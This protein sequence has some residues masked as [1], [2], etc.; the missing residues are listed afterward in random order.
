M[1]V[2]DEPLIYGFDRVCEKIP[3]KPAIIYLVSWGEIFLCRDEGVNGS[4]CHC[5]V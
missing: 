4:V 5:S 2:Y 1:R 3:D